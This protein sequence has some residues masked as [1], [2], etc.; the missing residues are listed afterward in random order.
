MIVQFAIW[1][2]VSAVV[3]HFLMY[4]MFYLF[5]DQRVPKTEA[6]FPLA[7]GSGASPAGGSAA[8]ALSC[9][10][11]LRISNHREAIG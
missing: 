1:L 8:S 9:E 7:K 4:G 6:E 11:D 10:R 5:A 2:T 3:V